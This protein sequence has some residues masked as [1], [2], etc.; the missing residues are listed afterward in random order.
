MKSWFDED[1]PS[2]KNDWERVKDYLDGRSPFPDIQEWALLD[3]K[4]CGLETYFKVDNEKLTAFLIG[5]TWDKEALKRDFAAWVSQ[6]P[7]RIR[8]ERE[9]MQARLR[10]FSIAN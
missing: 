6:F 10:N 8:F 4:L 7:P 2:Q 3:K 5:K 1:P 9:E